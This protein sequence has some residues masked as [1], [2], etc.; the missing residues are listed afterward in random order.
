VQLPMSML[1]DFTLEKQDAKILELSAF[2]IPQ[3]NV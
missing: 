3:I 2:F 1:I